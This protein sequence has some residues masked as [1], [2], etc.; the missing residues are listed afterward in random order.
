[1]IKKFKIIKLKKDPF[2]EQARPID[3]NETENKRF[4]DMVSNSTLQLS[5]KKLLRV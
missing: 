5:F 4:I 1:L 3:F 2:K